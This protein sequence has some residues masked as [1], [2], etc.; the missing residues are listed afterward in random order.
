LQSCIQSTRLFCPCDVTGCWP[1]RGTRVAGKAGASHAGSTGDAVP[2]LLSRSTKPIA[3]CAT[4]AL[5]TAGV[6]MLPTGAGADTPVLARYPYLT[7]LTTT[8][9]DVVWA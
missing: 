5:L 2:G 7:D 9:V 8:S 3:V 4:A 6:T 1:G